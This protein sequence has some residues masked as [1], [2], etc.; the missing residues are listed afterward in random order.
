[1]LIVVWKVT[2]G[3]AAIASSTYAKSTS[4]SG[5]SARCPSCLTYGCST[6]ACPVN[7][8]Y[9]NAALWYTTLIAIAYMSEVLTMESSVARTTTRTMKMPLSPRNVS[10]VSFGFDQ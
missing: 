5:E 7:R 2:A 10:A 6:S 9:A 3:A 1:M 4:K 8:P